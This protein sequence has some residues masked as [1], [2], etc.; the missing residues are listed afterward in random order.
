MSRKLVSMFPESDV[1]RELS[2]HIRSARKALQKAAD[3]CLHMQRREGV[4]RGSV[5]RTQ[6]DIQVALQ[7][8]S[9]IRSTI[10]G[11]DM[12]DP[13]LQNDSVSVGRDKE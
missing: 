13:D 7:G 12:S 2:S 1:D 6:R 5:R 3:L 4:D 8:I 10:R 11:Y 9:S